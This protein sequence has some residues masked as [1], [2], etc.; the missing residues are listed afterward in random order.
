M[1]Q[2]LVLAV[3]LAARRHAARP[4]PPVLLCNAISGTPAVAATHDEGRFIIRPS[5]RLTG[6]GY[7]Y[8]LAALDTP[9]TLLSWHRNVLSI[10]D[11]DGCSW[12]AA[13]QLAADFPPAIEPAAGGRAYA[14]SDNREFLARYDAS[15]LTQL[16]APGA[17]IGLG[18]D[19]NDGTR[20]R[21]GTGDGS[22]FESRDAGAS[23]SRIGSLDTGTHAFYR[24]AFDPANLDHIV[25]GALADGAFVSRDGGRTWT[26]SRKRANVFSIAFAPT[27]SN[28]VW[29]EA[30]DIA[31]EIKQIELSR[32]GG[33]TFT[34]QLTEVPGT[35]T[36]ING[37]LLAVH[38]RD[39]NVLYFVFG[40]SFQDYGTDLFRYDARTG[41]LSVA[42][43]EF[44][45]I[46]SIAFSRSDPGLMYL[47]LETQR[48]VF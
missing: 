48:G 8:G 12:R 5:E 17:I 23:W 18:T 45:D 32:D 25:A 10:S 44:D 1:T 19:P 43:N 31:T 22:I 46:N 28:V 36:L 7:T 39:P 15:G 9:H 6:V 13:G 34:M 4:A 20:L 11:D 26:N 24:F 33:T 21:A 30:F 47:G 27:D 14:W 35:V 42:H 2:A 37:A 3:F 29:I 38:P 16:K 40:T 41:S